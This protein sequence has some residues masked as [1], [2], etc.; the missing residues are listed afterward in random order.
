MGVD[1]TKR[2]IDRALF[3]PC[4]RGKVHS[5]TMNTAAHV[6][7]RTPGKRA[8]L[9]GVMCQRV[10][11]QKIEHY[12]SRILSLEIRWSPRVLARYQYI[13]YL[14]DTPDVECD[15]TDEFFLSAPNL[16]LTQKVGVSLVL[17]HSAQKTRLRVLRLSSL[18]T[19][20]I[21]PRYHLHTETAC[22]C[23][24]PTRAYMRTL[25]T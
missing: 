11:R 23:L 8:A 17:L 5:R 16:C 9:L 2:L 15:Q 7:V 1:Q 12:T 21:S 19:P 25:E 20:T 6:A 4:P 3:P 14:A 24:S 10:K 13:Q 18:G 22:A